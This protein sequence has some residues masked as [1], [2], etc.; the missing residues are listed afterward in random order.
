MDIGG[1]SKKDEEKEEPDQSDLHIF[2]VNED[3]TPIYY[4]IPELNVKGELYPGD[5]V[6]F[7]QAYVGYYNESEEDFGYWVGVPSTEATHAEKW[8]FCINRDTDLYGYALE[9]KLEEFSEKKKKNN[10]LI[11]KT[12]LNKPFDR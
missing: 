2:S 11:Y 6:E 4:D 5:V 12:Q 10:K 3:E 7:E 1:E 9:D 8:C